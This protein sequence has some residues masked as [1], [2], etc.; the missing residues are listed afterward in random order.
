M[1]TTNLS[2]FGYSEIKELTKILNAWMTDGLPDD[3]YQD[4]VH[5]MMNNNSGFVFLTNSE[6]QVAMMNGNK[7]ESWYSCPNCGHEGFAEDCQ[8]NDHGC[9]ECHPEDEEEILDED[10]VIELLNPLTKE[11][12]VMTVGETIDMINRDRSSDWINY[13]LTDWRDG[14]KSTEYIFENRC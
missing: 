12:V 5:P 8:L 14:L 10:T 11:K 6:F 7:L 2:K 3:F 13:D 1:T 9:N 4:E